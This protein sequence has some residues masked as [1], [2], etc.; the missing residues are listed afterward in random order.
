MTWP[1]GLRGLEA[2][3]TAS[4]CVC[5]S[6]YSTEVKSSA[7]RRCATYFGLSNVKA[8]FGLH[9]VS[10]VKISLEME[11]IPWGRAFNDSSELVII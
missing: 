11:F 6:L 7:Q 1:V 5:M 8:I 2:R 10:I 9:C 3:M 4:P